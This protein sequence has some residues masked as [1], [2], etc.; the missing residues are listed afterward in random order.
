MVKVHLSSPLSPSCCPFPHLPLSA[1]LRMFQHQVCTR[2][3][4][5]LKPTR[6]KPTSQVSGIARIRLQPY[7]SRLYSFAGP[8]LSPCIPPNGR[9]TVRRDCPMLTH[10]PMRFRLHVVAE[11]GSLSVLHSPVDIVRSHLFSILERCAGDEARRLG[12]L[13]MSH[14]TNSGPRP[15][16]PAQLHLPSKPA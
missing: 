15:R 10:V 12:D 11:P 1:L 7:P 5:A 2:Q 8:T 13:R 16:R 4:K 3:T 9:Y 6:G 14:W